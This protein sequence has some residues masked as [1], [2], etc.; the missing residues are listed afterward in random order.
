M[1]RQLCVTAL[2]GIA[3]V[4]LLCSQSPT[5]ATAKKDDLKKQVQDLKKTVADRDQTI[6]KLEAQI[7]NMQ[8]AAAQSQNK[9]LAL[10][11]QVEAGL[12][13]KKGPNDKTVARLRRDLDA[14]NQSLKDRDDTIAVLKDSQLTS[15]QAKELV[16][17]RKS[18][19]ELD[20]LRKAPFVHTKILKVKKINDAQIKMVYDEAN[21]TLAKIDGVRG[22]WIGKPAE[23]PTPE[24]AQKG[25]Q[26]GVVVLLDDPDTLPKFLDDPL[27]K[28]FVSKMASYWERPVVY[29]LQRDPDEPKKDDAK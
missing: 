28:Q 29:D 19:S 7:Q 2:C 6:Q 11:L 5:M 4:L 20:A 14:A 12:L 24:L 13:A 23:N 1:I 9:I 8:L 25:Y 22:V 15:A 18:A 10:Q 27:H 26:I 3:G 17:L 21:K 16:K